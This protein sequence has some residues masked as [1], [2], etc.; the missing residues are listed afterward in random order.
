MIYFS[1]SILPFAFP[2]VFTS[3]FI[4]GNSALFS[5]LGNLPSTPAKLVIDDDNSSQASGLLDEYTSTTRQNGTDN[6]QIIYVPQWSTEYDTISETRYCREPRQRTIRVYETVYENIPQVQTYT[7]QI[8]KQK[9][10]TITVSRQEEYQTAVQESF[11]VM[12]PKPQQRVVTVERE[13]RY[14]VPVETPYTVNQPVQREI[15]ETTYKTVIEKEPYQVTYTV[16]VPVDRVRIVTDYKKS[17]VEEV[18]RKPVIRMLKQELKRPKVD[19]TTE[20]RTRQVEQKYIQY[21]KRTVP[22]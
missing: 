18:V 5:E 6:S 16:Q 19:Y 15:Q 12:V 9:S 2:L 13:E 8:P 3:L 21:E 10:R 17:A 11:T 7:V 14:E 1:K 20:T 22:R 4:T